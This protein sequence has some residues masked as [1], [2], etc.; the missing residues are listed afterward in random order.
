[1]HHGMC[2]TYPELINADL[3]GF[4]KRSEKAVA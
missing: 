4:L 2:Q 1:L 3:L